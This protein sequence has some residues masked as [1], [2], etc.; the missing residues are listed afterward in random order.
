MEALGTGGAVQDGSL[1]LRDYQCR[2]G[3]A[4]VSCGLR[5]CDF[6]LE[7][8]VSGVKRWLFEE[9][10]H[11]RTLLDL[12]WSAIS[13]DRTLASEFRLSW[14]NMVAENSTRSTVYHRSGEVF[15]RYAR[16]RSSYCHT[17]LS[18]CLVE[19][20]SVPTSRLSA[21]RSSHVKQGDTLTTRS[22]GP[23]SRT[24]RRWHSLSTGA[25]GTSRSS[26]WSTASGRVLASSGA[27]GRFNASIKPP[28]STTVTR[29]DP[30]FEK[31]TS[32][33]VGMYSGSHL[34]YLLLGVSSCCCVSA[35]THG[36]FRSTGG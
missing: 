18:S 6:H 26:L 7:R 12:V 20:A 17:L 23:Q 2:R 21:V 29:L 33:P 36:A 31:S 24:A 27:I 8:C 34:K 28:S 16:R 32:G 14:A 9:S 10:L 30:A 22:T 5:A 13:R 25:L 19:I 1:R 15:V 4:E 11:A 3:R 35:N